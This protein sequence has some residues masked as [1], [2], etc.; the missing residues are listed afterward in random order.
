MQMG[1]S[2][3]TAQFIEQIRKNSQNVENIRISVLKSAC[4]DRDELKEI[5]S[6]ILNELGPKFTSKVIG[7][8]II[9]KKWRRAR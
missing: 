8:T 9:L 1:K 5:N 7:Y 4:R 3:L 6:K 2:G